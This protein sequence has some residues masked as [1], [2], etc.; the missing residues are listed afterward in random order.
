MPEDVLYKCSITTTTTS[1]KHYQIS[2][3]SIRDMLSMQGV[4][5]PPEARIFI[6]VPGGGDWSNCSLGINEDCPI[7]VCWEE[8][9]HE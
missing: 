1:R 6:E 7:N 2:D 5:V 8:T 3:Q 4:N 9:T